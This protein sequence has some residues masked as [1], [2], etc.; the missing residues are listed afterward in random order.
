MFAPNVDPGEL[1]QALEESLADPSTDSVVV[2][3]V[4][5][6]QDAG[7]EWP[8]YSLARGRIA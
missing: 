2:I 7:L 8:G 5:G 3:Y 1:S 6:L 4:P